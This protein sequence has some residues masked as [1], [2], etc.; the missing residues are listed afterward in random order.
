LTGQGEAGH[1]VEEWADSCN[2]SGKDEGGQRADALRPGRNQGEGKQQGG[3]DA[4]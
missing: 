2:Q 1:T 4:S 3:A